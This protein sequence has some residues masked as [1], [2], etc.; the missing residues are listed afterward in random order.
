MGGG[1]KADG[2]GGGFEGYA[3]GYVRM[4]VTELSVY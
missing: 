2:G 3:G 4:G 1:S